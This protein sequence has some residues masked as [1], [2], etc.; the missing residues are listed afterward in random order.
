MITSQIEQIFCPAVESTMDP[1]TTTPSIDLPILATKLFAPRLR[2]RMVRRVPLISRLDHASDLILVSAPAGFGKSTLLAEWLSQ[3]QVTSSW[4]SL[5]PSDNDLR[6]FLEY[7][8]A[9]LGR[10]EPTFSDAIV[11]YLQAPQ[12]PTVEV[13]LNPLLNALSKSQRHQRGH[14][15]VLVLDDY[16]TIENPTVHA[17]IQHWIEHLPPGF[18]LVLSSRTELPFS[19]SRWRGQG[20]LTELRADDLRFSEDESH[21]FL[22]HVMDLDLAPQQTTTLQHC[23]EGWVVG[24]QMAALSMCGQSDLTPLVDA[25]TGSH[26]FVLDYLTDEVLARQNGEVLDFLLRVSPLERFNAPLCDAMLDRQDSAEMLAKLE[27][28]NLFLIPLDDERQWF[29]FH[30]L[31]QQLLERQLVQRLSPRDLV[32]LRLR[33]C[34]WLT[35]QGLPDEALG[36]ALIAEDRERTIAILERFAERALQQGD[37]AAAMRWFDRVPLEWV[38]ARPGLAINRALALFLAVQWSDL[39]DWAPRLQELLLQELQSQDLDD[40]TEGRSL[41][42][43]ACAAT[44]RADSAT[45]IQASRRA[46]ELLP[47]E[48]RLLRAVASI[49]MGATLLQGSDY[50]GAKS[51]F[52]NAARWCNQGNSL[53]LDATC[54]YYEGRIDLIVGRSRESYERHRRSWA[55][56]SASPT[57]LPMSSLSLV[58]QA[59]VY[60][61][62]G[63]LERADDLAQQAID[64]NRGCFPFNELRARLVRVDIARARRRYAGALSAAEAM[65]DMMQVPS[66]EHWEASTRVHR[67]QTLAL[68]AQLLVDRY[69][70]NEW[71]EWGED[72]ALAT[73]EDLTTKLL[74]EDPPAAAIALGIRWLLWRGESD[75][76]LAKTRQ[77]RAMAQ[78]RQ[79]HRTIIESWLL[80]AQAHGTEHPEKVLAALRKALEIAESGRFVQVISDDREWLRSL[81]EA[82]LREAFGDL[83]S[84]FRTR[85]KAALE[86]GPSPSRSLA[87][88]LPESRSQPS[89]LPEILSQ[90]ELE[91]LQAVAAGGTNAAVGE[92]LFISPSTVKK[93]LE[94]IYG[95]LDVHNRVEA[96]HR[97]R[98]MGWLE[99]VIS[100]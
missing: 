80:E 83:T 10:L 17:L 51:A 5:E 30:H 53:G 68:Q 26:R 50:D 66:L 37:A 77:L 67:M 49:T 69:A 47:P 34:D 78:T 54:S 91:V 2:E 90:R 31:F 40:V 95:K 24:L 39:E 84:G 100:S 8:A 4:L 88:N 86:I 25:F 57:P 38:E 72:F 27:A 1:S 46:L 18:G 96:I 29:R 41:T 48:D 9:A 97:A 11:P 94:N 60:F 15:N 75:V 45:A 61:E 89:H 32:A 44:V 76:A 36:Q 6:R 55:E 23:T 98:K 99:E 64:L 19:V 63:E 3:T 58:G 62:W 71:L 87:A 20:R 85:V 92:T 16:H 35:H 7:L 22:S 13:L 70:T 73:T 81:P 74:P 33:A 12:L 21:S 82:L 14:R 93:H 59:E 65:N 43:T 56:E 79:W 52:A 42:L 28:K